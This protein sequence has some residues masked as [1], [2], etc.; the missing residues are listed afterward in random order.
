[1]LSRRQFTVMATTFSAA[2]ILGARSQDRGFPPRAGIAIAIG[3]QTE[4]DQVLGALREFGGLERLSIAEDKIPRQ[5]RD[6]V[7]IKLERGSETF[8]YMDNF[9]DPRSFQLTAYS[10]SP[11]DVWQP[12]WNRLIEKVTSTVG[13]QRISGAFEY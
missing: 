13:K 4:I 2:V 9:H 6:V 10:H 7:Q 8:F 5:G 11:K 3:N 1:M 12:V